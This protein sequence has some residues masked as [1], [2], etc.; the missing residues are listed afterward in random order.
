MTA[1][2]MM[3]DTAI[4]SAVPWHYGDPF[5]EQRLLVS[6]TGRVDLSHRE[7][8]TVSGPERNEWLHALLSQHLLEPYLSTQ[9]LSLSPNGH[10]EHDLHLI[11]DGNTVWLI[12]ESGNADS[13]V[14]Y[15]TKMKF[16]A[17][18]EIANVT[19][20]FAVVGAP[21]W[22]DRTQH[23]FP[24]WHSPNSYLVDPPI[25]VAYIP[26]RPAS[27]QVSEIIVP[28]A[29]LSA[30]LGEE[31]AG[32]WAWEAHR[33]RAGVP[34]FGFETD[35]RTIAHELGLISPAVHLQK[36]CY[37]GQETVARTYNLGKPPRR[38]VQLQ[39]DGSTNDLPA[40]NTLVL[41]GDVE[42]GRLTSVVHDYEN[43][44]LGLAVIKRNVDLAAVLTVGRVAAAQVPLVVA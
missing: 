6:G 19:E 26:S 5:K 14:A 32:T 22:I 38:L 16:R 12:C 43:G 29:E 40:I 15:L 7:V 23:A 31:L 34:R 21:G 17:V 37:R 30:Q 36:G 9:A 41:L 1:I 10:I 8:V 18:V 11:D 4:D 27:W 24:I 39:L 33:I 35:H 25:E 3:D 2:P 44:P 42:V 20:D 13:L 28:R